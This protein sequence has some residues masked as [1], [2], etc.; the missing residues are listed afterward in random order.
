[1]YSHSADNLRA[2]ASVKLAIYQVLV[3]KC[4]LKILDYLPWWIFEEQ[5]IA[6]VTSYIL[7][8]MQLP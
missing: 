5:Q 1:M 8:R 7:E 4:N 2:C 6:L 3:L